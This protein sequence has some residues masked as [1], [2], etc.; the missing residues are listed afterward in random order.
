MHRTVFP[1]DF[2]ADFGFLTVRRRAASSWRGSSSAACS[3]SRRG[4]ARSAAGRAGGFV[5]PGARSPS[6]VPPAARSSGGALALRARPKRANRPRMRSEDENPAA[7]SSGR[8]RLAAEQELGDLDRVQRRALAEVVAG[9]E[10]REAVLDASGRAGCGRRAR[11]RRR[12]RR[13][14]SGSPSSARR[15]RRRA[16]ARVVC[17]ATAAPRS[18]SRPPRRGR[19]A[20]ARARSVALTG[21]SGSSRILR[22]SS[23]SFDSS[24]N[25]SPSKSQSIARSCVVGRLGRAARSIRCS[26]GAGD[27]LVGRDADARSP[28]ASCSGF[29]AHVER[30]RAAVRVRDDAVVLERARRRS[31]RGRRA[32]CRRLSR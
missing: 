6:A 20:P 27:R 24:S 8:R 17:S 21:S 31:P 16:A 15:A 22:V 4:R 7:R 30:D 9:D 5:R 32:G 13:P 28:A 12:R 10:E 25:S 3:R 18:R 11:R 29:S 2:L 23:R 1:R 19:R 14:A 26:A